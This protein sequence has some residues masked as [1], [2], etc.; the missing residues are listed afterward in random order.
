MNNKHTQAQDE[1]FEE[2]PSLYEITYLAREEKDGPLLVGIL[3]KHGVKIER[4]NAPQKIQ[5]AYPIKKELFAF[6]GVIRFQANP[7]GL[8]G[9][10]TEL[11]LEDR[12]LRYLITH[13]APEEAESRGG[14]P[15]REGHPSKKRSPEARRP[16]TVSSPSRALSN[17]ALQEKIEEILQ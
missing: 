1:Q 14:D 6:L 9:L 7:S 11:L 2:S 13:P 17:E 10:N 3:A 16:F 15:S 4:E 5:L 12:L 8:L